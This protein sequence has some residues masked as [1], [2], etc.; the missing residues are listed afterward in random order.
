M[1]V[2]QRCGVPGNRPGARSVVVEVAGTGEEAA[3][4]STPSL[5]KVTLGVP[6]GRCAAA[7][8][9]LPM[10][11]DQGRPR[12]LKV[13][14]PSDLQGAQPLEVE[15]SVDQAFAASYLRPGARDAR[16]VSFFVSRISLE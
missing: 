13:E 2:A 14:I 6:P 15:L 12:V 5:L 11:A 10:S 9:E 16:L 3:L 8:F 1:D 7:T 4:L